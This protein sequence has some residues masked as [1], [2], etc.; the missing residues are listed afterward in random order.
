MHTAEKRVFI[1]A[2]Y[3]QPHEASQAFLLV[4]HIINEPAVHSLMNW[5]MRLRV[6]VIFNQLHFQQPVRDDG[7][8]ILQCCT[9]ISPF[10][11][12]YF[13]VC[14]YKC[15]CVCLYINKSVCV[16]TYKNKEIDRFF[17]EYILMQLRVCLFLAT[18]VPTE[19]AIQKLFFSWQQENWSREKHIYKA[20][21]VQTGDKNIIQR[22]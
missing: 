2:Q 13:Y 19:L 18:V 9:H 20:V 10:G 5:T 7:R 6:W 12:V 14:V 15:K 21:V 22:W 8:S 11:R 3:R 4:L 17:Q 16:Y 1:I